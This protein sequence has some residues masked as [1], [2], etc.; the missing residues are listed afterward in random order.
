[1]RSSVAGVPDPA[2]GAERRPDVRELRRD[3]PRADRAHRV[4]HQVDPVLVDPVLLPHELQHLHDVF[5]AALLHAARVR[6][7]RR[8]AEPPAV[9]AVD[10]IPE[11]RRDDVAVLFGEL[12]HHAVV[13]REERILGAAE[14]VQRDDEREGRSLR[15]RRVA[16]RHVEAIR[17]DLAGR[18]EQVVALEVAGSGRERVLARAHRRR[19]RFRFREIVIGIE[20]PQL[21]PPAVDVPHAIDGKED[22]GPQRFRRCRASASSRDDEIVQPFAHRDRERRA[23]ERA[24]AVRHVDVQLVRA[25]GNA[26]QIQL[27]HRRRLAQIA[28]R[29][30][31]C[32]RG[33]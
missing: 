33:P 30:R 13:A 32:P 26:L 9:R 21:Q 3:L 4:A 6:I 7:G 17:H 19:G 10:A 23:A 22:L 27:E 24:R 11:R 2:N 1:M 5:L 29:R 25:V 14:T 20:G 8:I 15:A 18:R 12:R 16:G 28:S 31:R